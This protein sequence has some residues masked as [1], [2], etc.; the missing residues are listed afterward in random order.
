MEGLPSHPQIF[1]A[2][3]SVFAIY[4]GKYGELLETFEDKS[5]INIGED[6]TSSDIDIKEAKSNNK[7]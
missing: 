3:R 2:I 4:F 5:M 6:D 7:V 1:C